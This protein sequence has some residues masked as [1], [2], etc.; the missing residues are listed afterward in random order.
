MNA[1]GFYKYNGYVQPMRCDIADSIFNSSLQRQNG[2]RWFS[3]VNSP[4]NEIWWYYGTD[5]LLFTPNQVVIY[6]YVDD[7]WSM[8]QQSRAAGTD[9]LWH[10]SQGDR[11]CPV[12]FDIDNTTAYLH[13]VGSAITGA[14]IQSGPFQIG[15]GDQTALVQR[16]IP[17]S[18]TVGDQITLFSGTFPGDAETAN[19]PYTSS[20]AVPLDARFRARYVRYQQTLTQSTSRVGIPRIGVIPS[21]RR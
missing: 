5:P 9:A 13:E 11:I 7:T 3:L 18:R 4:Y 17:D 6:N 20:G 2:F 8:G 16:V 15:P 21:S 12:M 1:G 14:Y 19:G 10:T